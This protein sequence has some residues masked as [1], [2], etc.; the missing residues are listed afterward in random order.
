MPAL[1]NRRLHSFHLN[2]S[3]DWRT[4]SVSRPRPA[5]PRADIFHA[6]VEQRRDAHYTS[7]EFE[8]ML[9]PRNH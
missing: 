7:A 2:S 3:R 9:K 8:A 6:W 4:W 1:P 5:P